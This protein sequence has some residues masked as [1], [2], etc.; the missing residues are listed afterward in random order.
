MKK[1]VLKILINDVEQS[2]FLVPERYSNDIADNIFEHV[3]IIL[4]DMVLFE[5]NKNENNC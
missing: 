1:V 3:E 5:E 4:E 2:R